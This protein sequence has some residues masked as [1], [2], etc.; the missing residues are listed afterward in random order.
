MVNQSATAID[1]MDV[2]TVYGVQIYATTKG[3]DGIHGLPVLVY[4]TGQ[5]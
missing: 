5:T 1:G 2:I 4:M 3:G